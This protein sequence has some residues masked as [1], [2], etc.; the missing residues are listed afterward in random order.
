MIREIIGIIVDATTPKKPQ[1]IEGEP[2]NQRPM[3]QTGHS[4]TIVQPVAVTINNLNVHDSDVWFGNEDSKISIY[5]N[6][7]NIVKNEVDFREL[8]G[9]ISQA[10]VSLKEAILESEQQ[11]HDRD[12]AICTLLA[13][14][15]EA[16]R[17]NGPEILKHLDKLKSLPHYVIT[18][19]I[20]VA[21]PILAK[22]MMIQLGIAP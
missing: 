22:L 8:L 2:L 7:W 4:G 12:V 18:L 6:K 15:E 3:I 5:K 20:N 9:D 13:A 19:I 1:N 16:K 17:E 11:K 21:G 14:E 10:I